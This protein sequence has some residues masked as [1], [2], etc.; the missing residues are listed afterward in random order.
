MIAEQT[1]GRIQSRRSRGF[2]AK[3]IVKWLAILLIGIVA[4]GIG[5]QAAASQ[6]DLRSFVPR[7]QMIDVDAHLMHI[8]CTGEGSPTII[9][10]AGAFS[11]SAEW[12]WAQKQLEQMYRVCSYDRAGNG[13]SESVGGPRDGQVLAHELHA[14]LE[15]AGVSEPLVIVGHS[16][17]GVLAPIYASL[18]PAAVEGLVLVDSAVPRNW[19]DYAEFEE[20]LTAFPSPYMVMTLMTR[21]GITRLILPP[22]LRGYGYPADI[23]AELTAF[24]ATAQGVDTW[25][26]EVQQAQW[27]LGQQL[28]AV[29]NLGDLPIIVLWASNPAFKTAEDRAV[30]EQIWSMLPTFSDNTVVQVVDGADHGSIIGNEQ[31]TRQVTEA[32]LRVVRSAQLAEPLVE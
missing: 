30:L 3:R 5:Y 22:E 21:V 4:L 11:F 16:L 6:I 23:I 25:N 7:G 24:K 19:A 26:A 31:Y 17:G 14:L 9:L 15:C 12:Y 1:D 13:Y 8:H 10:E 29:G 28:R 18:Y 32:V 20:Y 27:D 2:Y